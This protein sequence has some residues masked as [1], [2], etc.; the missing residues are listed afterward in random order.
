MHRFYFLFLHL[1]GIYFAIHVYMIDTSGFFSIAEPILKTK[2]QYICL[3]EM[4]K[5][6][7][8]FVQILSSYWV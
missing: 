3:P 4:E 5:W 7:F 8:D 2:I 6:N 1:S